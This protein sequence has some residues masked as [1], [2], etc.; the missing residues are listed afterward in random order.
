VTHAGQGHAAGQLVEP[1]ENLA[2]DPPVRG[3]LHRATLAGRDALVLTHGAGGDCNTPLL[4]TLAT[5]FAS[6]GVTTLRCDLPFRQARRRGP[7]SP[8]AG[9]RDR[10][11]LRRAVAAVGALTGG[12]VSLGG[13]SYG[14]RQASML[15]A[16]HP[17]LVHALLLLSYPLHPP[18]RPSPARTGHWPSL[19]TPALFVHGSADPFGSLDEV[20]AATRLVAGP[21]RLMTVDGAGHDL[22][23][24]RDRTVLAR[25]VVDAFLDLVTAVR[26]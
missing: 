13:H 26:T 22:V 24:G 25:A 3:V 4:Q 2:V 17:G 19:Q 23:R 11:G 9:E 15:A 6:R 14:G 7:P 21:V 5:T 16:A 20:S 10:E 1:F 18:G 8:A 12:A